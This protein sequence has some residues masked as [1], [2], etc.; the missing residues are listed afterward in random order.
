MRSKDCKLKSKYRKILRTLLQVDVE[1]LFFRKHEAL[2]DHRCCRDCKSRQEAQGAPIGL[3]LRNNKE[4]KSNAPQQS[5]KVRATK[6]SQEQNFASTNEAARQL[7]IPPNTVSGFCRENAK[8]ASDEMPDVL[9][10][11]KQAARYTKATKRFRD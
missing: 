3:H 11:A 5:K 7:G 10:D 1:P 9:R 2:L 6:D 8:I 4:R